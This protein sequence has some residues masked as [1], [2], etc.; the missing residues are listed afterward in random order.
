MIFRIGD[1]GEIARLGV[2]DAGDAADLDVAVAF[3]PAVQ[4]FS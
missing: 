2:L 3:E 1:E 4:P